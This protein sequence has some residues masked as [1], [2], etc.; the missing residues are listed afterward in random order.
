MRGFHSTAIWITEIF[1]RGE[2]RFSPQNFC[3]KYAEHSSKVALLSYL[4]GNLLHVDVDLVSGSQII[5]SNVL[6]SHNCV[7]CGP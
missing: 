7:S 6:K 1:W 3:H 4:S 5:A 2:N